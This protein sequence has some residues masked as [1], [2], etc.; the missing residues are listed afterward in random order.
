MTFN[1]YQQQSKQ[2]AIYPKERGLEYVTL[3][4]CGE[5]GEIANKVKK[6]IRDNDGVLTE[7]KRK[8]IS[9]EGADALWYLS[10]LFTELN[11]DFGLAAQE[12]LDKL[13]DRKNRGV[14]G[15]SGDNR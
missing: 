6:I 7:E 14:I 11:Y 15:G 3:G 4:L 8:D 12:N 2:T 5:V 1:E 13:L 10:Q 9:K